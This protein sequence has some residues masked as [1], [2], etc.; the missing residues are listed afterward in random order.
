M[1]KTFHFH[2]GIFFQ[3][4]V[5]TLNGVMKD[6][7]H[8]NRKIDVLKLDVEGQQLF[9]ILLRNML[10]CLKQNTGSEYGFLEEMLDR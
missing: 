3:L 6:L 7:G 4:P 2:N 5:K 9:S 1:M 8:E 10:F